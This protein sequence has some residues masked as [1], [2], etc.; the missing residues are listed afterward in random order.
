M[1]YM[2]SLALWMLISAVALSTVSTRL[3]EA[4]IPE[5]L[6]SQLDSIEESDLD[7]LM[8]E[9]K[10]NR[11]LRDKLD[12]FPKEGVS[13]LSQH[14]LFLCR[15]FKLDPA[16]VLS[17]IQVESNF[18]IKAQSPMG[19]LGLMQIMPQTA[20]FVIHQLKMHSLGEEGY[21]QA[22]LKKKLLHRDSLMNPYINT[23]I[24][25]T[26]LAWLR[27]YYQGSA[28][29]TLA[30]YNL[31]PTKMD[32]LMARKSFKPVL[33]RRYY[34]AVLQGMSSLKVYEGKSTSIRR[35]PA[36]HR[37]RNRDAVRAS[38]SQNLSALVLAYISNKV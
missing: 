14:I 16:L 12:V 11:I 19:A 35:K 28:Y 18:R 1:Q 15:E 36:R 38:L 9:E 24:G 20:K 29:H 37:R 23:A 6:K 32:A 31:G 27:D 17:V 22:S 26:Y 3:I 33:T 7:R 34:H 30:A 25:I 21:D 2:K 13:S 5:D 8:P 4:E 10:V